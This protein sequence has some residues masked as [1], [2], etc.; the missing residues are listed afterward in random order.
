M[1]SARL[2]FNYEGWLLPAQN[3]AEVKGRPGRASKAGS[4]AGGGDARLAERPEA[5]D[6]S[7]GQIPGP[8]FRNLPVR[9]AAGCSDAAGRGPDVRGGWGA[10]RLSLKV[11]FNSL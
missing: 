1:L 7:W 6:R 11:G 4:L 5:R 8:G 2:A 10:I 9:Q 3:A